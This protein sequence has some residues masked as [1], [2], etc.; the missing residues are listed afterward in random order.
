MCVL[1]HQQIITSFY[2]E[3]ITR[4]LQLPHILVTAF[5]HTDL[6]L[7]CT[8]LSRIQIPTGISVTNTDYC[9]HVEMML[10]C[11]REA[12]F[13]YVSVTNTKAYATLVTEHNFSGYLL[14][15][16]FLLVFHVISVNVDN[17]IFCK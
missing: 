1:L 7:V 2:Q 17:A 8:D 4:S 5:S 9:W 12:A 13:L 11:S 10:T 16:L 3:L 15:N 14:F 6:F